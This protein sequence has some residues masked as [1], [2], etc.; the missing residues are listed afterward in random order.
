METNGKRIYLIRHGETEWTQ[1]GQHTGSTADI[2]LNENGKREAAALKR[3]LQPIVFSNIYVSPLKRAL[4][5]CK[6]AGF[7]NRAEIDSDL[8]EWNYG[9]YEGLTTDEIHQTKPDWELFKDGAPH[10]ETFAQIGARADR[11]LKKIDECSGD[12]AL[13]S[14]GHFLRVLAA[15][16]LNLSACE[17]RSF[18]LAPASISILGYERKEPVILLWNVSVFL[19][20]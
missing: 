6:L 11:F 13:F 4:E 5:T 1:T 16:F 17:G 19:T 14:H 7:E 12:V 9:D 15:R 2:P 8:V 3:H 18:S 10:G 20:L